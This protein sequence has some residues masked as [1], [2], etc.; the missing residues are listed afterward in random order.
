MN[1]PLSE[2]TEEE[3]TIACMSY[4][5]LC[6]LEVQGNELAK[7]EL[8]KRYIEYLNKNKDGIINKQ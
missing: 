4:T 8:H 5:E 2:M 6:R 1:K 7:E 3:R